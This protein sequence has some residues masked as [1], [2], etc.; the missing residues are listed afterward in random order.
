MKPDDI[1]SK[2]FV[3]LRRSQDRE[4]RQQLSISKQDKQVQQIIDRNGYIPIVL[5][6]E[7]RSAKY[8]GRPIFKDMMDRIE[9]GE[10]RYISIWA[11][12]RL[13][14]NPIDG[15]RVIYALDTDKLLAIHTPSRTYRNTPDD[16]MV[17]AIELALAKK[18]NDDLGVQVKEGFEEKRARGQY[19]GPA[20]I[21]YMNT[22]IRPGERNI[23]PEPLNAPKVI[24]L[25]EAAATGQYTLHDLWELAR[26]IGLKSK[27]GK[28]LSKNTLNDLLHRRTYTGVFKYGGEGWQQGT[29]EPLISVELYTQVQVSM[30]W[31]RTAKRASTAKRNYPYKGVLVCDECGFNITAYSK[32]K[33]LASGVIE[34]YVF[35]VCTHKSKVKQCKQ[36]QLAR[37]A[38]EAEIKA[39][40]SEF[41]TTPE[42]SS[43][44]LE[45]INQFYVERLKQRNQYLSIWKQ[46]HKEATDK[47]VALDE[48]LET[49]TISPERYKVRVAEHEATQVRTK[50]LIEKSS[51]DA[52]R[53]LEL[54]TEVFTGVVNIGTSFEHG[55]DDERRQ[56]MLMLGLNWTLGN[57][58]VALTPREPLNAL[59]H[60]N[61]NTIWRARPDSNRRSSP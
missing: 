39:R 29:Y 58:K 9:A 6:P 27:A 24:Q 8:P 22:I 28:S 26:S 18:N 35:Y 36:P 12:S 17:L 10:A 43:K 5:P 57:K 51:Q 32:D 33:E 55:N 37:H 49:R 42:E 4:D 14:R 48:A 2:T 30:G 11:L 47:I 19:P 20:P 15:G 34:S 53:W 16:K 41:E 1:K 52:E 61:E 56:L 3:Y 21:G 38:I 50:E 44:C 13:S 46:D 31:V 54:A 45:Y 7:E 60:N 23:A 25:F 40:T 59:R